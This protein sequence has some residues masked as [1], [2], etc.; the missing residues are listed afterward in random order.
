MSKLIDRIIK[1][2]G[3]LM[4]LLA[5]L[6]EEISGYREG[7][8]RRPRISIIVDALE[9]LHNYSD[10]FHHPLESRL[11]ARLRPSITSLKTRKRLDEIEAQH[12]EVNSIT[13]RLIEKFEAIRNDQIVPIGPL[14]ADYQ[15]YAD[16]QKQHIKIE[17]TWMIPTMIKL[18]T[19]DD[20]ASVNDIL[21]DH[22]DPLF[23]AY[24]WN[25]YEDLYLFIKGIEG[26]QAPHYVL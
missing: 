18:L 17:N 23:V 3:H 7:A 22:P 8:T 9:Y 21:D 13:D 14:L 19:E 12:Q 11:I 26:Q 15:C 20:I 4:R 10:S 24:L 1:D 16:I 6:D 25:A 5:C 2:H